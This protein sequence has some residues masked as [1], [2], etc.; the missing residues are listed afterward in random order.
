MTELQQI[1]ALLSRMADLLELAA[2]TDWASALE[3]HREDLAATPELT[4]ARILAMYGGM[5]SLNDLVLYKDHQPLPRE[6]N[7][8]DELRVRLYELCRAS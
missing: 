7:E 4:K 6:N 1:Q 8:F 5:G 2:Q 3:R